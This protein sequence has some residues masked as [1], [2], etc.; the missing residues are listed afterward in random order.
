MTVWQ[1]AILGL[2][3]GLTE[4]LPVSSSGHL[5]IFQTAFKLEEAP[6]VFDTIVHLGTLIAVLVFFR[7]KLLKLN[8]KQISLIAV[9][10]V[11][12]VIAGLII[13]P[14]LEALFTSLVLTAGGLIFTGCILLTTKNLTQQ[15]QELTI[16][17]A[18]VIGVFQALAIIPGISRSGS[19]VCSA[20]HLGIKRESAFFFSFLLA[21]PAILGAQVLQL[22]DL[23]TL[24]NVLTTVN[25]VG[26][27]T[28]VAQWSCSTRN[29]EKSN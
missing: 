13:E 21:I 9:G 19:T 7:K 6:I 29:A 11:P 22:K 24:S 5:V 10:T 1:A 14:F 12:A 2:V 8:K 15:K 23:N 17:Q 28:A 26:F 20:L 18:I 4:F 27:T 25:I 16:R 3:Q